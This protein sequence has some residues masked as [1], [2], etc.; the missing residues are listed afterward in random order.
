MLFYDAVF[1]NNFYHLELPLFYT[2]KI[3]LCNRVNVIFSFTELK[4]LPVVKVFEVLLSLYF[5]RSLRV[6]VSV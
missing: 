4:N 2:E 3:K 1:A 5:L 6:F